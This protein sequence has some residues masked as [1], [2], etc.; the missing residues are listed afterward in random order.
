LSGATDLSVINPAGTEQSAHGVVGRNDEAGSV[1]K[2]LSSDVEED[3]EEVQS[4]K[5]K[6]HVDLGHG[7]LL[8]EVVESIIL[9][10]L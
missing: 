8:L 2:E 5:A 4:T 6:D 10:Q 3:Q 9:R 1:H 7:S